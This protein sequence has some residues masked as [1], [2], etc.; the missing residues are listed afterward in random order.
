MAAD[1]NAPRPSEAG[2]WYDA[3][4]R[5]VYEVPRA[6]G[7]GMRDATLRD[8]RKLGL[9]P[10]VTTII[11]CAAAP[12]LEI[13]KQ[14]QV[15]LAALTLPRAPGELDAVYCQRIM[16]DSRAQAE[17]A[18][19]KGTTIHAAIQ[20]HYQGTGID[21]E[22]WPYVQGA[23]IA[24]RDWANEPAWQAERAFADVMEGYGGKID[25][26]SADGN[27]VVLDFKTREF[28][29]D[30]PAK[31]WDEQL[32]QLAAYRRGYGY[33][34]ARCANVFVS[35]SVPGLAVVHEWSESELQRGWLMF[36]ALLDFWKARS[37]YNGGTK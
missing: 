5:S 12:G 6:D 7:K 24:V 34:A 25:L 32:M 23:T 28:S 33:P 1:P 16:E 9:L 36:K 15:L 37:G 27:G 19:E 26:C 2:R 10:S 8:A 20:S 30:K 21:T 22:T 3:Q 31:G 35:T 4:G 11:R 17:K 18:R 13:W 29:A 14:T